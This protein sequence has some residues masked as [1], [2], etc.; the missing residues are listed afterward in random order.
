MPD[1]MVDQQEVIM[2]VGMN[3]SSTLTQGA[4]DAVGLTVLKKAMNIEAQSAQMLLNAIPQPPV[5]SANLPPNLGQN[6]NTT[7]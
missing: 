3:I 5:S 1:F 7:A 2:S 4:N 6:I